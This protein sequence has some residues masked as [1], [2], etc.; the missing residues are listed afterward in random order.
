MRIKNFPSVE[1][2]DGSQDALVIEQ[3][4]GSEDKSRKVSP[5][6]LKQYVQTGDFVA[7]GEVK[8][9]HGNVLGDVAN[10]ISSALGGLKIAII[11]QTFNGYAIDRAWGSMYESSQRQIDISSLD[12]SSPPKAVYLTSKSS[13]ASVFYEMGTPTAGSVPFYF[14]RPNNNGTNVTT[15]V[16]AL[17]VY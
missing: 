15:T 2:I 7:T 5:A 13:S 10:L 14:V 8:D 6:Q 11:E 16:S 4:D 1:S 9:G 17:V 3:T 12:L